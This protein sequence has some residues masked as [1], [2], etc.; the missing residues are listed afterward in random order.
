MA[1]LSK[2]T[3]K[4]SSKKRIEVSRSR[5]TIARKVIAF[6]EIVSVKRRENSERRAADL[7]DLPRTTIRSWRDQ[8]KDH[9]ELGAF[10]KTPV[11]A[12]F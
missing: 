9:E 12:V 5:S 3:L 7:L 1:S 8:K 2:S 10:F 11:G 6:E 4:S